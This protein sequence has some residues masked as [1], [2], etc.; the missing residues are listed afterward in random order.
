MSKNVIVFDLDDTLTESKTN[1]T[2]EMARLFHGLLCEGI[3]EENPDDPDYPDFCGYKYK[4]GIISGCAY[5]QFDKQFIDPMFN[6]VEDNNAWDRKCWAESILKNLFLMPAS[7]SQ[8]YYF[9]QDWKCAYKETLPLSSKVKIYNAFEKATDDLGTYPIENV[10]GEIA[11]DRG[12]Q[13]T[14]SLCG[15][16]APLKV[17]KAIDPDQ[18]KRLKIAEIMTD[19]LNGEFEVTVGGSSSI[20]VTLKGRDKAYGMQKFLDY[21]KGLVCKHKYDPSE[22]LFIADA[23]FPGGNDYSVKEM[24]I[25]CKLVSGPEDTIKIIKSML[26]E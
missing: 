15:Q 9:W 10:Y 20:D 19:I 24:G 13:V 4:V 2:E 17:K 16:Q 21:E 5:E 1:I 23:I 25:E 8:L 18:S 14:F 22:V 7:G 3:Y 12:S 11:E 26:G 6:Y